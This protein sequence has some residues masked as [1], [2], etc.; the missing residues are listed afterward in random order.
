[1]TCVAAAERDVVGY[2]ALDLPRLGAAWITDLVVSPKWRRKGVATALLAEAHT[3]SAQ[4][5]LNRIFFEMQS[6]NYPAITLAQK[7]GYDFCGYNDQYYSN[8]DITL[9]FV[10]SLR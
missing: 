8:Q 3:W 4:R 1:M 9:I 6:K 10:R 5:G 7:Q 2:L